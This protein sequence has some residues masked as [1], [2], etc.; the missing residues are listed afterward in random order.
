MNIKF[1]VLLLVVQVSLVVSACG[2]GKKE[3]TIAGSVTAEAVMNTAADEFGKK[4]KALIR[5]IPAGSLPGIKKLL[6]GKCEMAVSSMKMPNNLLWDAQKKGILIK[7]FIVAYDVIVIIVNKSNSAGSLFMGQISDMYTGL[8]NDWESAAG[9]KGAITPVERDENSGTRNVM[10]N[11]FFESLNVSNAGITIKS[12]K[13]VVSYVSSHK[14]AI[15]Y[16][17]RTFLDNSVKVI[18]IH[19]F[20]PSD[21]NTISGY[22]PL[23]REVYVYIKEKAFKGFPR[24]FIEMILSKKG[25]GI[26][27]KAGFISVHEVPAS[28]NK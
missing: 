24:A 11:Q 5:Y 23:R 15:G 1:V 22:Y 7:E 12:D 14:N 13:A 9:Y 26:I 10:H 3:I 19:G 8:L 2:L 27:K 4:Q 6:E 17:S 25:Q 18:K 21:V 16:I 20:D 28:L